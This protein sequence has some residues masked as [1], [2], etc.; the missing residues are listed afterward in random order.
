MSALLCSGVSDP[1]DP[2][3]FEPDPPELGPDPPQVP[4]QSVPTA[5][6]VSN[7]GEKTAVSPQLK[8]LFWK[9]VLFYKVSLRGVTLGL[10]LVVFDTYATT[11][12]QVLVGSLIFLAYT[13]YQTKRGKS[14]IDAGEF[15]QAQSASDGGEAQPESEG[16]EAQPGSDGGQVQSAPDSGQAKPESDA[17]QTDGHQQSEG[18]P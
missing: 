12:R 16:G 2:E 5:P 7:P 18:E 4:E 3:R 9:L 6:T 13:L 8:T 1:F 14:R 10:L 17:E 11:G 15:E